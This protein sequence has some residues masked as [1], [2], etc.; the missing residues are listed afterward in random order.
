MYCVS[1]ACVLWPCLAVSAVGQSPHLVSQGYTHMYPHIL[2]YSYTHILIYSHTHTYRRTDVQTLCI[3]QTPSA[4]RAINCCLILRLD[5]LPPILPQASRVRL[6]TGLSNSARTVQLKPTCENLIS[7]GPDRSSHGELVERP[8]PH[9][10][11]TRA[12]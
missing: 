7:V 3:N 12:L 10:I 8:L 1:C 5:A 4:S 9:W 11:L 6:E 2:I